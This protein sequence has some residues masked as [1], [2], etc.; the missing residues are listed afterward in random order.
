MFKL[1]TSSFSA[2][3]AVALAVSA[4]APSFAWGWGWPGSASE[5]ANRDAV[6]QNEIAND[7]GRLGGQYG[8]L[9]QQDRAIRNQEQRELARNGGYLTNG[10]KRQL[11]A[12]ENNLQRQINYDHYNW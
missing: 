7:Q 6:L 12:E 11:N 5:V 3:A 4:A 2:L 10:Q 1:S 8:R 9:S